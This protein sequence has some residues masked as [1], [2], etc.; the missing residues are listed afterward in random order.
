MPA[1]SEVPAALPNS[2]DGSA[3]WKLYGAQS[4]SGCRAG[5]T[6]LCDGL[7]REQ[8]EGRTARTELTSIEQMLVH[9]VTSF[10]L[11]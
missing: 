9:S 2:R 4:G 8:T 10:E 6:T 5:I 7:A 11:A 1:L 3:A